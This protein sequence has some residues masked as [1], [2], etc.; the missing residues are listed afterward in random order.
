VSTPATGTARP[1]DADGLTALDRTPAP[2][3]AADIRR[4]CPAG[5]A[6]IARRGARPVGHCV[7]ERR[8]PELFYLFRR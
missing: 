5:T 3:R 7:L 1:A 6:R 4:W 2:Q 8:R